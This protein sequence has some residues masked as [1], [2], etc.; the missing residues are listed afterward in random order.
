MSASRQKQHNLPRLQK[1]VDPSGAAMPTSL[2]EE[3]AIRKVPRFVPESTSKE[4]PA[5]QKHEDPPMDPP[6]DPSAVAS[7]RYDISTALEGDRAP[8]PTSNSSEDEGAIS[9]NTPSQQAIFRKSE[10]SRSSHQSHQTHR[11]HF[12]ASTGSG[13]PDYKDQVRSGGGVAPNPNSFDSNIVF[14]DTVQAVTTSVTVNESHSQDEENAAPYMPPREVPVPSKTAPPPPPPPQEDEGVRCSKR[15]LIIAVVAVVVIIAG[16]VGGVVAAMSGSSSSSSSESKSSAT[17]PITADV[18][19]VSPTEAPIVTQAPTAAP[20]ARD[21]AIVNFIESIKFSDSEIVY[22]RPISAA[23]P[24]EAAVVWLIENTN[25]SVGNPSDE[26][27][28]TQKYALLVLYFATQGDSWTNSAGW[29]ATLATMEECSCSGITCNRVIVNGAPQDVVT[30]IDLNTNNL[31]GDFPADIALLQ[32]LQVLH[33]W[34]NL[35]LTGQIPTSI[36]LLSSMVDFAVGNCS[37]SGPLPESMSNWTNLQEVRRLNCW[38]YL[39]SIF[40]C[41]TRSTFSVL[42]LPK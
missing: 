42:C 18:P 16:V 38:L 41:L 9:S 23:T 2:D 3:H 11:S 37:M 39:A 19:A 26:F 30:E 25:L 31:N 20:V 22:P 17:A 32:G 29:L 27:R 40:S 12:M 10:P 33:L 8:S 14:A 36:G 28:L 34:N 5:T 15:T 35:N 13:G 21:I 4:K 7:N 1:T 6:S 24:E